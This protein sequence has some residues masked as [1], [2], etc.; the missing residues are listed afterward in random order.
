MLTSLKDGRAL[1]I[2][3]Q[4]SISDNAGRVARTL[5]AEDLAVALAWP[6]SDVPRKSTPAWYNSS[7]HEYESRQQSLAG[8][9]HGA[10]PSSG[11]WSLIGTCVC[12]RRHFGAS[13]D[14]ERGS[15]GQVV[16][17]LH[18]QQV[19]RHSRQGQLLP[20]CLNS[21]MSPILSASTSSPGR[22]RSGRITGGERGRVVL[23]PKADGWIRKLCLP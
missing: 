7:Q 1:K 16:R 9:P 14:E 18:E 20:S 4:S 19:M 11:S 5:E 13:R 6:C 12:P 17:V 3:T 10:W 2:Q 23:V 15:R 8:W 21:A 22:A